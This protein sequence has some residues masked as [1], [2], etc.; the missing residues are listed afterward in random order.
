MIPS[1][2]TA[3]SDGSGAVRRV[4]AREVIALPGTFCSPLIFERLAELLDERFEMHALSWMTDAPSHRIEEVAEWVAGSI[5]HAG[6]DPVLLVGHS[7]GGAIALQLA[8]TRPDLVGALMLINTG[9]NMHHHGDVTS[10]IASMRR[11]GT[12]DV[13]RAV[14]DRSFHRRPSP[15][16][17]ERLLEYGHGVPVQAALDALSSQ[18]ATDFAP[19][20]G[21]LRMPVSVVHGRFDAVRTVDDAEA[22]TAAVPGAR[23]S[24]V[25]AGHSPMYETPELV[26][27]ALGDLH[28]RHKGT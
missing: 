15:E 26:A 1:Q 18:H 12:A 25:D 8:L 28:E 9:P 11:D 6:Q 7:T 4:G 23:L 5:C 14:M 22:M 20:M 27:Q 10:L 19:R 13:V 3:G 2:Q 21:Q 17:R 24:L 16:V